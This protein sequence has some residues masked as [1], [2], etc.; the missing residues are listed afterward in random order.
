MAEKRKEF[1]NEQKAE[2][3]KRD[4]A[5]CCFSG[6]NLWLLDASFRHGWESDWVDHIRPASRGG[7]AGIENGVC[8]TATFNVKK[9]NNSADTT[10]LFREGHPTPLYFELFGAPSPAIISRLHRLKNLETCDWYFNR[11]ITWILEGLHYR[12]WSSTWD[13]LPIRDDK[14]WFGAAYKKL[15]SFQ[16]YADS[17]PSLE[18]R[19]LIVSPS[20]SQQL[21]LSL[22]ECSSLKAL[23]RVTSDLLPAYKINSKTWNEYF[24]PDEY[25]SSVANYDSRRKK[26]Y[27][28]A[29]S[30]EDEL[31]RDTFNCI[32]A[33]FK[34]RYDHI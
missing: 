13:Q 8:A 4:R 25:E 26:A 27:Q 11:S 18:T 7:G 2:I 5:T 3:Y 32:R 12:C 33:D 22:R 30:L 23:T 14:Y 6:A 34:I 19:S 28:K 9:R 20:E 29:C 31:T 15:I 17:F 21:L 16:K 1:K 10:Y 24:H